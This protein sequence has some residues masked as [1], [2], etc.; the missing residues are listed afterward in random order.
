M[1][2]L[3]LAVVTAALGLAT[4]TVQQVLARHADERKRRE[5]LY[6]A[7]LDAVLDMSSRE[8]SGPLVVESQRMWL[9]ASDEVL[10]AVNEYLRYYLSEGEIRPG[11]PI[12]DEKRAGIKR[13][14][15]QIRLAIRRDLQR[16]TSLE[17]NGSTT[18][19]HPSGR[20]LSPSR[21][22]GTRGHGNRSSLATIDG[23]PAARRVAL[24]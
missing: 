24:V 1:N 18:S 11:E 19:G 20:H 23:P 22:T 10:R 12:S 3:V 15:A 9:Y 4:W 16:R 21:R 14:D 8:D 2:G 5:E 7:L 17:R 13:R 6:G